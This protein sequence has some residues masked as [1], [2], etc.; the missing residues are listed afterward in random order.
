MEKNNTNSQYEMDVLNTIIKDVMG[1][2]IVKRTNKK[3]AVNGRKLFSKILS[4]RGYTRS[5]IGKYLKKDHSTIVYYMCDVEDMIKHIDG[6]ADR[7]LACKN[8]F[9]NSVSETTNEENKSIIGL[10]L[11]IDELLFD[12][13][14]LKE[15]LDKYYRLREIVDV[16]D[17]HTPNGKEFFILKKI[18]LM[19]NEIKNDEER[20]EERERSG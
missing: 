19:F 15:K 17:Y 2:E 14:K 10:K 8:Y 16:L 12:R 9:D 18:R 6:M 4:D 7:Y 5:E 20:I 1:V 11:R 13:E 3:E